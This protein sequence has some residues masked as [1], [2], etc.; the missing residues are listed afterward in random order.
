[1]NLFFNLKAMIKKRVSTF[2][3]AQESCW[4]NIQLLTYCLLTAICLF[5]IIPTVKSQTIE[6]YVQIAAENNPELKAT[7]TEF[8]AALQRID[9][10][11]FLEDPRLSFGYFISPIETRVGPQRAKVS[12]TQMLPWFGTLK[13]KESL[14]KYSAEAKF[15]S[16]INEKNMLTW[17]VNKAYYPLYEVKMQ[18]KLLKDNLTILSTYK[19]L[20]TSAFENNRGSL[21]DIIRVDLMIENAET[22]LMILQNQI[23]PLQTNFN[24]LLNRS[25]SISIAIE[26]SVYLTK[27]EKNY[28]RDS[29]L[30]NN[31]IIET[32]T[33]QKKV[34]QE[35]EILARK[36]ALPQFSVGLDYAFVEERS[37][38]SIPDNGK[39]AF[40]PMI[41]VSVPIFRKK[42]K[43]AIQE[44]QLGQKAIGYRKEAIENELISNYENAAFQIQKST[45]LIVLYD[46][47]IKKTNQLIQLLYSAYSNSNKDFEE[48]LRMEQ[49]LLKYEMAKV[50][51]QKNYKITLAEI[52]YLTANN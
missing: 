22:E 35:G 27:V 32:L 33:L 28:R 19:R 39:D 8:E 50:T 34:F 1:M 30:I 4:F 9:Q 25:D 49:Q 14:A 18:L 37:D 38:V 47:Q 41:S 17:K 42:Y 36:S 13:A 15:Q 23:I 2:S 52:E 16:F 24:K 40:M 12:L 46:T 21:S 44:S 29:L 43:A 7:Y 31:P 6:S 5:S 26:D 10:V 45:D 3:L 20:A 48:V 11:G 51:A